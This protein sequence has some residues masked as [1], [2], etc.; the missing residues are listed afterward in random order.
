MHSFN[1][2]QVANYSS[3]IPPCPLSLMGFWV[4]LCFLTLA[5]MA[6]ASPPRKP[7][8]V[9]FGRNYVPTW[10]FDHIKYLNEGREV[11]LSLDKYTGIVLLFHH[12]LF[13]FSCCV[14][15]LYIVD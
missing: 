10:A 13:S 14:I 1:S 5:T 12:L 3:L 15:L 11:H 9:S 7:V 6:M 4:I 2:S 8:D